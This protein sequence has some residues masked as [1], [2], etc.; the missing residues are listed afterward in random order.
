MA[1]CRALVSRLSAI[2]QESTWPK[3]G[4]Y[5]V[6]MARGG[7]WDERFCIRIHVVL[8]RSDTV[9]SMSCPAGPR[10][11]TPNSS[12]HCLVLPSLLEYLLARAFLWPTGGELAKEKHGPTGRW[13]RS[14]AAGQPGSIGYQPVWAPVGLAGLFVSRSGCSPP[15][16]LLLLLLLRQTDD[17]ESH[18]HPPSPPS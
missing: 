13:S 4:D 14:A 7:R 3:R 18:F 11:R 5:Q 10:Y 12:G 2:E 9:G 1:R 15:L 6:P 17:A 8:R 16:L